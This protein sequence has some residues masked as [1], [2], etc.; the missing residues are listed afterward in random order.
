M[1]YIEF[2]RMFLSWREKKSTLNYSQILP[3]KILACIKVIVDIYVVTFCR[4]KEC[5]RNTC[6]FFY[7]ELHRNTFF[8][9]IFF[10]LMQNP[11]HPTR[12]IDSPFWSIS[13]LFS[14]MYFLLRSALL[15]F[16]VD[17]PFILQGPVQCTS[18]KKPFFLIPP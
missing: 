15:S 10:F 13:D 12:G 4:S 9:S 16:L 3:F 11:S 2:L 5:I 14:Q 18:P 8:L 1:D 17:E 6:F 7:V